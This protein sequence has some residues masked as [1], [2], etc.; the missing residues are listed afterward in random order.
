MNIG[1]HPGSCCSCCCV[2]VGGGIG[3]VGGGAFVVFVVVAAVV[4]VVVAAINES[5]DRLIDSLLYTDTDF[6]AQWLNCFLICP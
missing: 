4:V 1:F 3:G 6:S 2:V 5:I